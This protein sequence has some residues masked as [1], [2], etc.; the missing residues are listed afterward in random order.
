MACWGQDG[1]T[2]EE[3]LQPGQGLVNGAVIDPVTCL[4]LA[5][6]STVTVLVSLLYH[7]TSDVI[8]AR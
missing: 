1:D 2:V 3:S 8:V 4:G 7:P 5:L 6:L